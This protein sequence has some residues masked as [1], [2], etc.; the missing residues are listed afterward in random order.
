VFV[1]H[2]LI[3]CSSIWSSSRE[4]IVGKHWSNSIPK[5]LEEICSET[6]LCL[7]WIELLFQWKCEKSL[8]GKK[9]VC[10]FVCWEKHLLIDWRQRKNIDDRFDRSVSRGRKR[11]KTY[12]EY[13]STK[14][15][16]ILILFSHL[17]SP[18]L[19]WIFFW[20]NG[21]CGS[22]WWWHWFLHCWS[23]EMDLLDGSQPRSIG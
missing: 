3:L 9:N 14:K 6:N 4:E 23:I 1:R 16:V 12:F 20:L 21:L 10:L 5:T 19:R 22:K 11:T 2:D 18:C 7:R 17:H 13:Q 15:L 8:I